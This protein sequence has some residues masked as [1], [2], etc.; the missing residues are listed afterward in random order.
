LPTRF[1]PVTPSPGAACTPGTAGASPAATR[2]WGTSPPLGGTKG[3]PA[4]PAAAPHGFE[5]RWLPGRSF[6]QRRHCQNWESSICF[7]CRLC[8]PSRQRRSRTVGLPPERQQASRLGASGAKHEGARRTRQRQAQRQ[9]PCMPR[10]QLLPAPVEPARGRR[11]CWR[12]RGP[13]RECPSTPRPVAP[14]TESCPHIGT[15]ANLERRSGMPCARHIR[16]FRPMRQLRGGC[17]GG[18]RSPGRRRCQ[19]SSCWN[20]LR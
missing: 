5:D 19:C 15:I 16:S 4:P 2:P 10:H 12:T 20:G 1:T 9:R 6:P 3:H 18:S 17:P 13:K 8:M 14:R 11:C 7:F